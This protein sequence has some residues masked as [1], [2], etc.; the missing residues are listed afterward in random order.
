MEVNKDERNFTKMK[1]GGI[2]TG[3]VHNKESLE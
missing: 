3:S 2:M 1:S